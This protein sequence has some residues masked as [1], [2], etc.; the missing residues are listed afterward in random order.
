MRKIMWMFVTAMFV[1]ALLLVLI[2]GSQGKGFEM[3][4][5]VSIFGAGCVMAALMVII[6]E[7]DESE[8]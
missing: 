4:L 5:A 7:G 1:P 6:A 8:E 3:W 2:Y